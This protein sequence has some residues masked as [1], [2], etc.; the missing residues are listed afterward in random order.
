LSGR[1]AYFECYPHLAILGLSGRDTILK[2]KV[3]HGCA[4]DWNKLLN[5]LAD[6]I[7]DFDTARAELSR[8][9]KANEDK[10]DAIVCAVVAAKWS[11]GNSSGIVGSLDHGYMVTPLSTFLESRLGD[12]LVQRDG[13]PPL[14]TE[15]PHPPAMA[16]HPPT[17][18]EVGAVGRDW[19]GPVRMRVNDHGNLWAKHNDWLG[20]T[21]GF[22]HLTVSVQDDDSPF[23]LRFVP[24]GGAG[25]QGVKIDPGDSNIRA[26]WQMLSAG[27][28]NEHLLDFAVVYRYE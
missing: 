27:A 20:S 4:E 9:T 17:V 6:C 2:Y 19:R 22:S 25:G 26:Y 11:M 14:R 10:L 8:Q 16:P 24:F 28:C 18:P 7:V 21:S 12:Q 1:G 3:R 23:E 5:V 13:K 15:R